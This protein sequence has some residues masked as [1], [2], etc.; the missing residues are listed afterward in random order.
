MAKKNVGI[1]FTSNLSAYSPVITVIYCR[2]VK[3]K[4]TIYSPCE[5]S[6]VQLQIIHVFVSEN[7]ERGRKSKFN[8]DTDS[9][10]MDMQYNIGI[11]EDVRSGRPGDIYAY[12]TCLQIISIF[13]NI[14][15]I[16]F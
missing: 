12:C 13:Y 9:A 5:Y 1:I 10:L 6:S 16:I 7:K 2:F 15:A 4:K 11:Q 3:K 14:I 8:L